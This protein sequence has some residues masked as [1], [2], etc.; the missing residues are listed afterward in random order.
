MS[1]KKQFP[2]EIVS[3]RVRYAT[4]TGIIQGI[5]TYISRQRVRHNLPAIIASKLDESKASKGA[6]SHG[7]IPIHRNNGHGKPNSVKTLGDSRGKKLA[8][9]IVERKP[10]GEEAEIVRMSQMPQV[11]EI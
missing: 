4:A 8:N 11:Q 1:L 9:F 3:D 7:R 5:I 2:I 6:H 10:T